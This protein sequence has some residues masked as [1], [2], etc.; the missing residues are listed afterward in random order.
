MSSPQNWHPED[1]K[2]AIKKTGV[3]LSTLSTQ[4]GMAPNTCRNSLYKPMPRANVVIAQHLNMSLHRLWP[5]W[6][7]A[8]GLKIYLKIDRSRKYADTATPNANAA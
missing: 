6:Y 4:N 8:R 3:H 1:V 7:D 5:E 2:A